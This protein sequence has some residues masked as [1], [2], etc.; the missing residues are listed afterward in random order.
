MG[1][2]RARL[3]EHLEPVEL[4]VGQELNERS[5][6]RSWVYFPSGSLVS[7]VSETRMATPPKSGWLAMKAWWALRWRSEADGA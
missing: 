1:S 4:S 7:L 3:D 6:N 2:E 5:G